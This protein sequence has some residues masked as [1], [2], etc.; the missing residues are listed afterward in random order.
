[1]MNY[2]KLIDGVEDNDYNH[3]TEFQMVVRG[4]HYDEDGAVKAVRSIISGL[5]HQAKTLE[6]LV[7]GVL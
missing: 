4:K 5:R 6:D 7:E 1:M 2:D 3:D